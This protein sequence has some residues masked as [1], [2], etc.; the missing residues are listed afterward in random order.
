MD[1]LG[2]KRVLRECTIESLAMCGGYQNIE[3]R[4]NITRESESEVNGP[5]RV[6]PYTRHSRRL[7]TLVFVQGWKVDRS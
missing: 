6:A 4:G 7:S 5:G 2:F 1:V 3:A